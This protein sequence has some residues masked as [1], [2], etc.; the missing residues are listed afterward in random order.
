MIIDDVMIPET[1][2]FVKENLGKN[3]RVGVCGKRVTGMIVG[4]NQDAVVVS[5]PDGKVGWEML[6]DDV[7]GGVLLVHSPLNVTFWHANIFEVE[8]IK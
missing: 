6:R 2:K 5:F 7:W 1:I 3:V 8:L 4:W